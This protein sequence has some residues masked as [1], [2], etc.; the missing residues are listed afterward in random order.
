MLG[1]LLLKIFIKDIFNL[2]LDCNICYFVDDIILHSCR[3]SIDMV[4]GEVEN[5][6]TTILIWFDQNGMVANPARY[7]MIFLGKR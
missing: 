7:R 5:T 4:I 6:I 2:N 3:P 1:P